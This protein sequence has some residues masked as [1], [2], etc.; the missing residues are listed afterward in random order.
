MFFIKK[1]IKTIILYIA[2]VI[3]IY[4]EN[5]YK[6]ER[7]SYNLIDIYYSPSNNL[8][9]RRWLKFEKDGKEQNTIDWINSFKDHEVFFDNNV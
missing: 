9:K 4:P 6:K 3:N 8:V 2:K 1:I 5:V 7:V